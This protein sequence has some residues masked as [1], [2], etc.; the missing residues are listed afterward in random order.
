MSIIE[1]NILTLPLGVRFAATYAVVSGALWYLKPS[2]MFSDSGKPKEFDTGAVDF[3][4]EGDTTLL[5]WW[6]AALITSSLFN[7]LF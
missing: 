2:V 7:T 6:L 4:H 5:P 3:D 1:E